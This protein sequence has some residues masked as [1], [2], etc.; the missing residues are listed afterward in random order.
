MTGDTRRHDDAHPYEDARRYE[1][2]HPYDGA[3]RPGTPDGDRPAGVIPQ[4]APTPLGRLVA[5]VERLRREVLDAQAAADGRALVELAKGILIGQLRCT[6]AAAARQLDVLCRESGMSPL[7]LAADIV[8]QASRDHVSEIAAEFVERT[9][10]ATSTGNSAGAG[11]HGGDPADQPS[12]VSVRLRTAESGVLAV[13]ADTQAVAESL[14]TNAL[15]P[16]GAVAVAVWAAEPDGSL[17]LAGHAGFPPREAA[18]WRHVPPGVSTVARLALGERRLVT[19][20]AMDREGLPS[21]G[22]AEWPGGGRMAVP[23]GTGGRIQGVLEICWPRPLEPQAPQIERQVEA[24]A[25]LCA[26]TMDAAPP[27]DPAAAE[28]VLPDVAELIDL[29]EGLQDPAVVLTPVLDSDGRLAD[30]RIRH[31][32]SRFVDPVGRPRGDVNGALLLE[33]YPLAA[34][35]SG[36]FDIIERVHATG[37]PFR[38]ERMSLTALVDQIPITSVANIS[39]SRHGSA[40]LLIWRIQDETAR[41]AGLLQHAQRLG[42][43][44]GFEE[45][46]VTGETTWNA[47]LYDLHGLPPTAPPV[48]LRELPGYAHP[49]DSAAVQ[50]FLRA[51]LRHRRPASVNLRLRRPDGITRHIRVVAEP[52][53]DADQRLHTVRGAYQDISAQHWTEVALAATRDQLAH[54]EAESAERSRLA[55]QLQHAIMP[56]TPPAIEAPGLRVAVRYR[57]AEIEALV[58]GDWYDTVV[59]PSGLIMLSVGDVAGHGIE[60]ATGMVVLR[61]ALRGLAVTGAGPAQL[62]SWLNTVTHHL[63]KHVTA[64]A[65]CGL[66]DPRTRVMRWARAGH[67]PPV[68]V[69]RGEAEAFPLIEGLLLG[70]LPDVAYVEREVQLEPDDTLLMYTDGLVERRDSSVQESLGHLVHAA[71]AAAGDLDGQL[72][73]LLAESRS[74]TDDDTCVIGI[75]VG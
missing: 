60:A 43:I 67:L 75:R 11:A 51:V 32:G 23:T 69:R 41:L 3:R 36:L 50:R 71:A 64:T 74:D 40:V 14:L 20:T 48:R 5:T 58:G 62:L 47:Q 17:A 57:P 42:R 35:E 70:A 22:R 29:A 45:N 34:G 73:R 53:L 49:D 33:A 4:Q 28:A 2:A 38:A 55:L 25:E 30:F 19:L 56:P 13:A 16:L 31:T 54:T 1:D 66:F 9:A 63:A 27:H 18:R 46:L 12:A 72:D 8:N 21:V 10:T 24:L 44:G 68:L 65:V 59:L 52:V 37:E 15:G 26:R 61:N 6:P 39:V 7:A